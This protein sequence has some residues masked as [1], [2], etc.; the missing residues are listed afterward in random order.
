MSFFFFFFFLGLGRLEGMGRG[1]MGAR[2][3][4]CFFIYFLGDWEIFING[5][6]KRG[7]G[8]GWSTLRGRGGKM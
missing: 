4:T 2:P 1:G 3:R 8:G 7:G 5:G 6:G